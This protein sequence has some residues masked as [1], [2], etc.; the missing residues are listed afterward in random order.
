MSI[1]TRRGRAAGG[2]EVALADASQDVTWD[3]LDD[4]LNRIGN[5]LLST[6]SPETERVAVFAEN[7]LETVAAHL[8][9][10]AVGISTVPVSFHLTVEE[11]AYILKDSDSRVLLVGPET[12]E[13]GV[14][15]ALQSG[16]QTVVGWRC[17]D[18]DGVTDWE[19]WLA[20]AAPVEPST[21]ATPRPFLH[22][23]SGTTGL[24]KGTET[25]PSMFAGGD[26]MDEHFERVAETNLFTGTNL[27]V[28]PLYHT[29]P[30]ASLRALAAGTRLVVLGRFDPETVLRSIDRYRVSST[31]M[32]PT[33]F[34]R[35]LSL[36]AEVRASYDLSS[37]VV[38]AH[39]GAACPVDVKRRMIEWLGP[40]LIEAYGATE[41]GTTN[42]ITSPE[43]LDH[44]GS[45][46]RTLPPFEVVVVSD[47]GEELPAGEVGTLYFRDT[48]GRGIRYHNDPEKTAAAHRRPGEFTLGDVGYVDEDGYVY[49]TDRIS[50]MVISG[51]VNIYP[52]E[53]EAVL[54][55][56]PAVED[57]ACIGVP[58]EEMGEELKALVVLDPDEPAPSAEDLIAFARSSLAHYKCPRSIDLVDDLGRNAMGK[59][60]KRTLRAPYWPSGRT[61]GG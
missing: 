53:S 54:L 34:A 43:W 21:D 3:A 4:M 29:G 41:S 16:V 23:T 1:V 25:P 18:V 38:V 40:V 56:H 17:A 42:M 44:P 39:T 33:H 22:Y 35:L 28:S 30:L 19:A 50:D 52:A 10:I 51:G 31:V 2:D 36:P 8:G 27:I 48:T 11:L 46:G 12:A 14:A 6:V 9:A 59:L 49:I 13:R 5:G 32:V 7:A 20:T 60:N 26:T 24:P 37:L 58:H 45:V 47:A 55:Q 15:A 57:V 61:I